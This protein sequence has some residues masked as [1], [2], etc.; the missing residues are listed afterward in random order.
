MSWQGCIIGPHDRSC[1]SNL[2]CFSTYRYSQIRGHSLDIDT[3]HS[4]WVSDG[5]WYLQCRLLTT[6]TSRGAQSTFLPGLMKKGEKVTVF[7]LPSFLNQVGNMCTKI[8][9]VSHSPYSNTPFNAQHMFLER[10]ALNG[11]IITLR[12]WG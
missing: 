4:R 9:R 1:K 6:H 3:L 8:G 2:R 11:V 12:K 5:T 7:N 10:E